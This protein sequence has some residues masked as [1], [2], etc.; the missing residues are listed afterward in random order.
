MASVNLGGDSNDKNTQ[1]GPQADQIQYDIVKKYFASGKG[2]GAKL[3]FG[4][5]DVAEYEGLFV[6]PSKR[7][8]S[9]SVNCSG[10][11]HWS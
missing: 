5:A 9:P 11:R 7:Y 4:G 6:Q 8:L 1:F 2:S 3:A 10:S